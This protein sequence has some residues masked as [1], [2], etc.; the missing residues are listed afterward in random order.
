MANVQME[1]DGQVIEVEAAVSTTLP[2]SVLLGG[3]VPE[4]KQLIGNNL[5]GEFTEPADVM[6]VVT[7]AQAKKH[8]EEE[9]IR[10]EREVLSG[11]KPSPVEGLEQSGDCA[12]GTEDP[13]LSSETSP[14]L[15]QEQRRVLQQQMGKVL[16]T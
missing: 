13:C 1:I 8:L 4:L 14:T 10:R 6:V 11:V 2:V 15:T 9:I 16:G 3:D 5:Q 12:S 7:R